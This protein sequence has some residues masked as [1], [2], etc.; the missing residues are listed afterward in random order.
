M[1][2]SC[3]D[4][5]S[6]RHWVGSLLCVSIKIQF[7]TCIGKWKNLSKLTESHGTYLH[8][9]S[10]K[11]ENSCRIVETFSM[12]VCLVS[13]LKLPTMP[14]V[15]WYVCNSISKWKTFTPYYI[16]NVA[17]Q[18]FCQICHVIKT[19]QFSPVTQVSINIY[20]ISLLIIYVTSSLFKDFIKKKYDFLYMTII[21]SMYLYVLPIY[22][23]DYS[24]GILRLPQAALWCAPLPSVKLGNNKFK[25]ATR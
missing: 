23:R 9:I 16:L 21:L 7:Y 2:K 25:L 22:R 14:D 13:A 4:L 3:L 11:A 18:L 5:F 17:W 10:Y 1:I 19:C 20:D 12:S 24:Q 6:R 8:W 15:K